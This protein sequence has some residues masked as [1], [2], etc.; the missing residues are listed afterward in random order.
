MRFAFSKNNY[1]L[2]SC[3]TSVQMS[4]G[5]SVPRYRHRNNMLRSVVSVRCDCLPE[6]AGVRQD[7]GFFVPIQLCLT[8]K[9]LATHCQ[10][11]EEGRTSLP[12]CSA[13]ISSS[14]PLSTSKTRTSPTSRPTGSGSVSVI[15]STKS[16]KSS[17]SAWTRVRRS[18]TAPSLPE[19]VPTMKIIS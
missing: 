17:W 9:K 6:G 1:D 13:S 2:C 14:W 10:N 15:G 19:G 5:A 8:P 3:L 11:P 18:C 12:F 16:M 4:V 7:L